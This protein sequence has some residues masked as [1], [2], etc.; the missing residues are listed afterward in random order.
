MDN[1]LTSNNLQIVFEVL[2]LLLLLLLLF[3]N[4]VDSPLN[5]SRNT[6]GIPVKN[7]NYLHFKRKVHTTFCIKYLSIE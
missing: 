1:I 5:Q 7:V 4:I 2:L 3:E 6:T